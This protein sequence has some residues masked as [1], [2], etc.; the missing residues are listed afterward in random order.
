MSAPVQVTVNGA[1]GRTN[2]ALASNG[3]AAIASSTYGSGFDASGTINGD[4]KGQPWGK[5]AGGTMRRRA[6]A[7][8]ARSGFREREDDRRSGRVQRAGQLPAPVEPTAG[9]TFTRYGLTAF[10][11]QYW[12]GTQ[13][14]AV[15]KAW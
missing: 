3:A 10:T 2:V 7:G 14:L 15:P 6:L 13:W 8:L 12:N 5:A 1:S 9:M 4:R 11:V